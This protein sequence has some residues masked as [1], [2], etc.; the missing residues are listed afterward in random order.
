MIEALPWLLLAYVMFRGL[1]AFWTWVF[2]QF[3]FN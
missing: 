1:Y 3:F 2:D